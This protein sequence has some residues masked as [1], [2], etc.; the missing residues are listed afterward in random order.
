MEWNIFLQSLKEFPLYA[1]L[2][3]SHTS[4][5]AHRFVK[6][7][8]LLNDCHP[9]YVPFA[10]ELIQRVRNSNTAYK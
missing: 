7:H 1:I 8:M 2:S 3:M 4:L 5:V 6:D 10:K 9:H